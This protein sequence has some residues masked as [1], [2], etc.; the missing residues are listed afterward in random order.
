MY[1]KMDLNYS[2]AIFYI[3]ATAEK[4]QVYVKNKYNCFALQLNLPPPQGA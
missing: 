1:G 3:L 2:L 4:V